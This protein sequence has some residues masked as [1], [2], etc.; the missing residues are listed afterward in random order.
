MKAYGDTS[1]SNAKAAERD[2]LLSLQGIPPDADQSLLAEL[3]RFCIQFRILQADHEKARRE[4]LTAIT[5]VAQDMVKRRDLDSVFFDLETARDDVDELTE[6][7]AL[8]EKKLARAR[9]KSAK[10][11]RG[12][13]KT[14]SR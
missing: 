11:K 3:R 10:T 12:K 8:L 7:V 1:E 5:M 2:K 13:K 4:M 14:R 9:A 6:T